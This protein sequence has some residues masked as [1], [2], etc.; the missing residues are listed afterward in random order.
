[1][2]ADLQ[3]VD[4]PLLFETGSQRFFSDVIVVSCTPEQ[5]LERLC[6]R[7]GITK[8]QAEAKIRS[9]MPL[10][11][12]EAQAT[13]VINNV[14]RVDDVQKQVYNYLSAGFCCC[15]IK[16]YPVLSSIEVFVK[17]LLAYIIAQKQDPTV[18]IWVHCRYMKC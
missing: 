12:K 10:T 3:V 1:M 7:D 18:K 13:F 4:M 16:K 15:T 2:N 8:V 5:Q 6:T 17:A 11:V 9:Q 14:G